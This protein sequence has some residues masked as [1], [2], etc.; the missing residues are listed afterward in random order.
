MGALPNV[1]GSG[2]TFRVRSCEAMAF[3]FLKHR[4]DTERT[5]LR[6]LGPTFLGSGRQGLRFNRKRS[7]QEGFW[8]LE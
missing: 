1:L 6:L 4:E 2:A 8:T 3:G 5:H 7:C